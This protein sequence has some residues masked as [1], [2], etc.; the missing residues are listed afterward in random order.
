MLVTRRSGRAHPSHPAHQPAAPSGPAPSSRAERHANAIHDDQ[1]A[2]DTGINIGS[3]GNGFFANPCT[4]S[5]Q[6]FSPVEAP[7]G[8]NN[9]FANVCYSSTDIASLE[10]VRPCM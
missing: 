1:F 2:A 9:T 7:M 5:N 3:G 4:N 10:P 6:P 8:S